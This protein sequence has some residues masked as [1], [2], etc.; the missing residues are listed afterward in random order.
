MRTT[1]LRAHRLHLAGGEWVGAVLAGRY[2]CSPRGAGFVAGFT[3][4]E[5]PAPN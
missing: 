2:D 5:I 4:L 3:S 1:C